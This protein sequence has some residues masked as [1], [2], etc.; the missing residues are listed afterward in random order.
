MSSRRNFIRTTAVGMAGTL[1]FPAISKASAFYAGDS[2]KATTFSIGMAGY[3]FLNFDVAASIEMMKKLDVH[4]ISVKDFHLPLN[5]S[6]EKIKQVLQQ[7]KDGGINVYTVG[8]IYMKSKE[9]VDQAFDYAKRVGVNMIVG[10]PNYDLLDYTEEKVKQT[11]IKIAIHNH[12]PEDKLY[13]GPKQVWDQIKDRDARM[14]LCLDVGHALRAGTEPDEA[15][16]LYSKRLFDMHI[17]DV[18][19]REKNASVTEIGRGVINYPA[20]I[21]ALEKVKYNG[22]ISVEYEKNMKDPLVGIAESVGYVRG[23]MKT[24]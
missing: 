8:V 22:M 6:D 18:V 13:P 17:K 11:N 5:S 20:L 21:K 3:T 4:N 7:F 12:G 15:V 14:G 24:V 10:V 23:V 1:S 2:S 16:K 19:A 9:A